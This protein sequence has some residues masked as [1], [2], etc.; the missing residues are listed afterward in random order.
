M[1]I[2]W[3]TITKAVMVHLANLLGLLFCLL[4]IFLIATLK[5]E[6]KTTK[7][8]YQHFTIKIYFNH[9]LKLECFSLLSSKASYS[10]MQ[11]FI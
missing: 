8:L 6:K 1:T 3:T 11:N 2:K 4:T 7:I 5:K 9:L 10:V